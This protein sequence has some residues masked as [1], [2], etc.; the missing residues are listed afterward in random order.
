MSRT[1]KQYR[2]QNKGKRLRVE[3]LE[4]RRMLALFTVSNL[5][6]GSVA[7]AGDL[8][9]SLRQALFDAN[10]AA[11]PDSIDF[12]VTG[13]IDIASQLPT[14]TEALTITGP[15]QELLTIDAGNGADNE[16]GTGDGWRIF[17][18]SDGSTSIDID[19]EITDL[20]LTGGD[21]ANGEGFQFEFGDPGDAGGAINSLE[22]LTIARATIT[23][24]SSG[25]GGHVTEGGGLYLYGGSGG[26]GGGVHVNGADLTI[27]DSLI[28]GNTTGRGGNATGEAVSEPYG[29]GYYGPYGGKVS[30]GAGGSGGGVAVRN[31][32]LTLIRSSVTGNSTGDGGNGTNTYEPSQYDP[33][34]Y[35]QGAGGFSGSGGGVSV[36]DG[37]LTLLD[38]TITGNSTGLGGTGAVASEY[39]YASDGGGGSGGGALQCSEAMPSLRHPPLAIIQR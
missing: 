30:G 22:N 28:S 35:L 38:S 7:A 36:A 29:Y 21:A 11:G 14:I 26:R 12:S 4:D 27:I 23:G 18:I 15:G 17:N 20:T 31:G 32:D 5:S 16:F 34:G 8:P 6:D 19:V 10:V 1:G 33:Y 9:G 3:S 25:A 24:N 13:T 2:Q 39:G 37:N